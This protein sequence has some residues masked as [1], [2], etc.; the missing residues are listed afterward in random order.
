M[1]FAQTPLQLEYNAIG[2]ELYPTL[3]QLKYT[4]FIEVPI[5]RPHLNVRDQWKNPDIAPGI[6]TNAWRASNPSIIIYKLNNVKY[7]LVN[8]RLVNYHQEGHSFVGMD[9]DH[10]KT[11]NVL[12]LLTEDFECVDTTELFNFTYKVSHNTWIHGQED[13]RLCLLSDNKRLGFTC[14]TYDNYSHQVIPRISIGTCMPQFKYETYC[15][16]LQE[17]HT[18]NGLRTEKNWIPFLNKKNEFCVVYNFHPMTIFNLENNSWTERPANPNYSYHRGG[19]SFVDFEYKSMKGKLCVVH[20]V[21]DIPHKSR[22]YFHRFLWF[23][24]DYFEDEEEICEDKIFQTYYS[25]PFYL[26]HINVEF[27]SGLT[28]SIDGKQF[29]LTGG[30]RERIPSML[31]IE[32]ETIYNML[33]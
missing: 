18:K 20:H 29:I 22:L 25:E 4:K 12:L 11:R 8:C 32:K 30:V 23:S 15:C 14:V 2:M 7:Y 17:V 10:I 5:I 6:Q 27:C 33:N 19:T 24:K 13:L 16:D 3:S 1:N 31:L 28:E 9:C 21:H 26:M